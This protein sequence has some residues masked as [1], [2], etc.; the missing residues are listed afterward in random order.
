MSINTIDSFQGQEKDVIIFSCVRSNETRS[1]GFMNDQRR[2]NVALT[3][4]RN[5]LFVIGDCCTVMFISLCK[6]SSDPCWKEYIKDMINRGG[7]YNISERGSEQIVERVVTQ[8]DD[9]FD[10]NFKYNI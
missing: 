5:S 3:R 1:V 8:K 4:A 9:G 2:I 6:L 7:Y 10:S